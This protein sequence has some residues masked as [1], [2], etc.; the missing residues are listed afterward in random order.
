MTGNI[1]A[2]SPRGDIILMV[3]DLAKCV[4][5]AHTK[6]GVVTSDV[7]G[8]T[9]RKHLFGENFTHGDASLSR[10][11]SLQMGF[12]GITIKETPPESMTPVMADSR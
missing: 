1:E 6:I 3:P 12:G 10:R 11:L 8:A 5:D 4:I 2:T 9:R 7:G